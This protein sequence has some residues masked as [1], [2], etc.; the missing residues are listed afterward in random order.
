MDVSRIINYNKL[1]PGQWLPE[2]LFHEMPVL[3][4]FQGSCQIYT[5]LEQVKKN[6]YLNYTFGAD[7]GTNSQN[8]LY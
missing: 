1:T 2:H 5:F 8:Y 6:T 4:T 3:G 7:K